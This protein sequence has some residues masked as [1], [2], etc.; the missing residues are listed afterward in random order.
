MPFLFL[1]LTTDGFSQALGT[2]SFVG[3]GLQNIVTATSDQGFIGAGARNTNAAN[4]G[5]IGQVWIITLKLKL[6]VPF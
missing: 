3:G 4:N 5:G 1:V 2:N 6:G